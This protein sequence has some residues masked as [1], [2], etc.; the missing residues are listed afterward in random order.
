MAIGASNAKIAQ[1]VTDVLQ[2]LGASKA[3]E[4][5]LQALITPAAEGS[6]ATTP[7]GAGGLAGMLSK[8]SQNLRDQYQGEYTKYSSQVLS[9]D[10]M[11]KFIGRSLG[12]GT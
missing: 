3:G 11:K 7:G 1:G 10:V 12:R 4:N 9:G 2:V 5:K 6:G 8:L